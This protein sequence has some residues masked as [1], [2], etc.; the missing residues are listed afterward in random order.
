MRRPVFMKH[1]AWVYHLVY[2]RADGDCVVAVFIPQCAVDLTDGVI[3]R[4]PADGHDADCRPACLGPCLEIG[5]EHF[6]LAILHFLENLWLAFEMRLLQFASEQCGRIQCADP[7]LVHSLLMYPDAQG[8]QLLL[9]GLRDAHSVAQRPPCR[10]T[11]SRHSARACCH[12]RH[13]DRVHNQVAR[14]VR[15]RDTALQNT[16]TTQQAELGSITQEQFRFRFRFRGQC[17]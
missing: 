17:P 9:L 16:R 8:D 14:C 1:G 2:R 15:H 3:R 10:T 7:R 5:G 6:D 4:L 13:T 12:C 11:A